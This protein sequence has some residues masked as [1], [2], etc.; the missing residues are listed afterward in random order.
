M[1]HHARRKLKQLLLCFL[2]TLG[3]PLDTDQVTFLIVGRDADSHLVQLF[4]AVYCK[5]KDTLVD[6]VQ[7]AIE[8]DFPIKMYNFPLSLLTVD[9]SFSYEMSVKFGIHSNLCVVHSADL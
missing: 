3:V 9:S 7:K 1:L 5:L 6:I 8:A 4:D 2:H